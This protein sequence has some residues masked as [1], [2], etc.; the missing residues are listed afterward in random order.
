MRRPHLVVL[1][2]VLTALVVS[3]AFP[4]A[5]SA[6]TFTV[7]T[8]A[9]SGVGSLRQ[10][11]LDANGAPGTDTI[12]F[13]IPGTGPQTIAPL[14]ALPAISE[15]LIIDG[16]SQ[17]GWNGIPLIELSGVNAPTTA[18]G[19]TLTAGPA[20]VRGLTINRFNV[21]I[22][23]NS[24]ANI[25]IGCYIG[26]DVTGAIALA[27]RDGGIIVEG[28]RDNVIGGPSTN[29]RNLISGNLNAGV[30]VQG[31]ETATNNQILGNFIGTDVSGNNPL[32]NA[33]GVRLAGTP[34]AA[35]GAPANLVIANL[36]AGNGF[37]GVEVAFNAT[38]SQI[39][40]N[41]IGTDV[42]GGFA[43]GNMV[44]IFINGNNTI[45]GGTTPADRNLI[46]GNS[47]A[48]VEFS[49]LFNDQSGANQVLGNFIGTNA[50]G[51]GSIGNTTGIIIG[52]SNNVIG[53]TTLAER[54]LIA[55]NGGAGIAIPAD[56]SPTGN[57]ILG[58]WIG[59]DANGTFAIGN[60]PGILIEAAGNTVGGSDTGAGN[61]IS[62]NS[63]AGI[64]ISGSSATNN[65]IIGNRIGT[66]PDGMLA[67]GNFDGV[68]ISGAANNTI[69]V[70][71]LI[72]GN[73][74]A[75]IS[76]N[77][78]GATGNQIIGNLIGV[79]TPGTDA[80]GNNDG[81]IIASTGNTLGGLTVDLRNVIS[82]N[83]DNGVLLTGDGNT[84][85][86][87]RIGTIADGMLARGNVNGVLIAGS[88]NTLGGGES[89]AGNLIS[90]NSGVGVRISGDNNQVLGNLIGAELTGT[91]A[92]GNAVG[93][94]I[95]GAAD[96]QIGGTTVNA[97]N[98]ISGNEGAGVFITGSGA[99][100]NRV[101][102][103]FIGTRATGLIALG[104]DTGVF[105]DAPNNLI[106][107][108]E[109]G[110]RNII[111]GNTGA[112]I[113]IAVGENAI[114]GNTIGLTVNGDAASGN[115]L[116]IAVNSADNIIGAPGAGNVISGND[117]PG[118][119]IAGDDN[120]VAANFIGTDA[121]GLIAFGNVTGMIVNGDGNIIG[122]GN[123][124]S[125]NGQSGI[126]LDGDS[127]QVR[128]AV[129]GT[130]VDGSFGL[131]NGLDGIAI[132]GSNNIIGGATAADRNLI[133]ANQRFGVHI[134]GSSNQVLGS[135][136]GTDATG[137]TA[138]SN[139]SGVFIT[140]ANNFIGGTQAGAGNLIA[141][142]LSTG[143]SLV[144]AGATGNQILG[145]RIGADSTGAAPL[146]NETGIL[147]DSAPGNLIGAGNLIVA[148]T[149]TGITIAG[150]NATGN[151]VSGSD[152]G[153]PLTAMGNTIGV[154]I[155]EAAQTQIGGM[156]SGDGNQIRGNN[157][158]GIVVFGV[159]ARRSAIL[160]NTIDGNGAL[161]IDLGWNGVSP[162][163]AGDTDAGA[164]DG[165]NYPVLAAAD[166]SGGQ[167]QIS[168]VLNS[169]PNGQY[170]LEFFANTAC[171]LSGHG[172]GRAFLGASTVTTNAA[173]SVNFSLSVAAPA[174]PA[175]I[176]AT[177]TDAVGNTSEFS[178]CI[179]AQIVAPTP[180]AT[181][182]P[183]SSTP[184]RIGI[185][186]PANALWLLRDSLTSGGADRSLLFGGISGGL[187]LAGDWNGDGVAT[188]GLYV[189][190]TAFW[191]MRNSNTSG[192]GEIFLV[193]GGIP[194]APPV[195]GYW[196]VPGMNAAS[197]AAT[198][199]PLM[200]PA[201][202]PPT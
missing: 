173:G 108:T 41:L 71:N 161:G 122:A 178:A 89:G 57:Q 138:L 45:I 200:V 60:Q 118:M 33:T 7:T 5:A 146:P 133:A 193:Y 103:N 51:N 17:P 167:M 106:G 163:D 152:I 113:D 164:N 35:V 153:S 13:N 47:R 116:G 14:S 39:R 168:G 2:I 99:I 18:D 74:A 176:T 65:S 199:P 159:G 82:G 130:L 149:A 142:N 85:I 191:F 49:N 86:G 144:A 97:R 58:N 10:A 26:T 73:E 67:L 155:S 63:A 112:G 64:V 59:T 91:F 179:N 143:V 115:I 184:D 151:Q 180:T 27:N 160:G 70:G 102:G 76:I 197:L 78:D 11:I 24:D 136:I 170:R 183:A 188:P 128:G 22:Q 175:A 185:Y 83:T 54:N 120:L 98:V 28:A 194:G 165:Q 125:G 162:N 126:V 174:I 117:G 139:S 147:I 37:A 148:N 187:P 150:T 182:P 171:D 38:G 68:R 140:G 172:E 79:N 84:V 56:G 192:E 132:A 80:V 69:G 12:A 32:G 23:I 158:S 198:P 186:N 25:I 110:A 195:V 107:G 114:L 29:D 46:A 145:N 100:D 55:G 75:G 1:S 15:A 21:G 88:A 34:T 169:L 131:G 44:G 157:L 119:T 166:V 40:G 61:L 48:G 90:G 87:N 43:L 104:N 20:T 121:T 181:P 156:Q 154:F 129:I 94:L 53:G 9:D 105:L 3:T 101:Q 201:Q 189:P 134:S 93:V 137:L 92:L 124:V 190:A 202:S 196:G 36:I 81:V 62:G 52:A 127:N 96:N 66:L 16:W 135:Y 42:A 30:I 109:P 19:L 141:G 123:L 111:A 77:G 95:E 50:D 177:A 8:T 6:A 31:D 4:Q 72:S